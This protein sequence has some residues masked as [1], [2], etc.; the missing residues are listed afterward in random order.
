[1]T[2]EQI[3]SFPDDAFATDDAFWGEMGQKG[4]AFL[5]DAR[6]LYK[7]MPHSALPRTF[8]LAG[9]DNDVYRSLA[10]F[11]RE[12]GLIKR[13]KTLD[14]KAFFE[15]HWAYF[16]RVFA[17]G[18]GTGTTETAGTAGTTGTTGTTGTMGTAGTTATTGTAGTAGTT[19]T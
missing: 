16:F 17:E 4:W 14:E 18:S 15:F 11:A 12:R 8:H 1:M 10:G 9:F 19:V 3:H 2:L 6:N 13:G 5:R 7:P